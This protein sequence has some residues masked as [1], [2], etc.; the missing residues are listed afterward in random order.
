[1]VDGHPE[2]GFTMS[3]ILPSNQLLFVRSADREADLELKPGGESPF[4]DLAFRDRSGRSRGAIEHSL[5]A[6][7]FATAFGPAYYRGYLGQTD[8][9]SVSFG[10]DVT[11]KAEP[12]QR[13][14]T[15]RIARWSLMGFGAA[16]TASS[17]VFGGMA[18][19]AHRDF[20]DASSPVAAVGPTDRYRRDT[21]V[22]AV[23]LLSGVALLG[24]S[25]LLPRE[26]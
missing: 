16:L 24:A 19:Q 21:T 2:P 7:L 18:W 17:L 13:T 4:R 8:A 26:P 22:M 25:F 1:M 20:D 5:R 9:P 12:K 23:T 14:E 15:V 10:V 6:G 3:V 11:A